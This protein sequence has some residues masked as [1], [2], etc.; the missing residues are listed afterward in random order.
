MR[1]LF[2][3]PSF[4]VVFKSFRTHTILHGETRPLLPDLSSGAATAGPSSL[5]KFSSSFEVF[6]FPSVRDSPS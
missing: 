2:L 3:P 1:L 4:V 6:C 5:S